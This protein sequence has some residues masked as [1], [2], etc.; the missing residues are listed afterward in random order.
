LQISGGATVTAGSLDVGGA[1]AGVGQISVSGSGAALL[2][3]GAATVADNGTGVLSVLSGAS[4]AAASLT[5]GSRA[6]SIGALV[7][8]GAGSVI[9][10]SGALNV[11]TALG[12]G[13]LTI[14]P[15][16]AVH[17]GV[18]NLRGQVVLEGGLL[19]PTVQFIA[20][21][22]TVG[23]YGTIAAGDIV[24]EGVI[25]ASTTFQTLLVQGAV[26][27]GGTLTVN[28]VATGSTPAGELLINAG[29]TMELAG[30]VLDAASFAGDLT[31]AGTW[32]VTN[33]VAEV[34][35][36]DP[37]GSGAAGVLRLDDIT[38]FGGTIASWG[39]GDQFVISGG[40]LSDLGVSNG[41]T[42]TVQ[43]S[44]TGGTDRIIFGSAVSAAG[45]AIVNTNT[46]QVGTIPVGTNQAACF[47]AGTRIETAEGLV[48]VENLRIGD[49][50]VTR[51]EGSPDS[52]PC[53]PII[54]I[55]SRAVRC[56]LHP[57]PETVW[58][59]W[60]RAGAFA[61]NVPLRDLYLSPITRCSLT[62]CWC[63]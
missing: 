24:D 31:P 28:G 56:A 33:S 15:G 21:Y 7:V 53:E 13:E 12:T 14:G 61:K 38:G 3:T 55:G 27:G 25:Q 36:S 1:V 48:A 10:L 18:V 57:A 63:R 59:V 17:A 54:W 23:G 35:F 16:A 6:N 11:G 9:Q 45:F 32:S 47:A 49:R 34:M 26:L 51:D 42:L 44:G 62:A 58:P 52:G 30:A 20:Q 39:T 5:I 37:A 2:V 50:V 29:A 41:D 46:I 43:D 40:A 22:Q 19:D 4:F 60:V 8:S